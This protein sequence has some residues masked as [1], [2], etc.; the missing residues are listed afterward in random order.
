MI[1][2]REG[3]INNMACPIGSEP[4][5][6]D[7]DLIEK[8]HT[9]VIIRGDVYA[10]IAPKEAYYPP[11][12]DYFT[13]SIYPRK[14]RVKYLKFKTQEECD[15]WSFEVGENYSIEGCLHLAGGRTLGTELLFNV[16]KVERNN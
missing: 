11:Y 7:C 3:G 9:V 5:P 8:K 16:T 1:Q 2:N 10:I 12:S 14:G 15:R 13:V 6:K 4:I